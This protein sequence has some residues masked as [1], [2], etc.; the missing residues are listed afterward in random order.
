MYR[1]QF[2]AV[3]CSQCWWSAWRTTSIIS[4][5]RLM[6]HDAFPDNRGYMTV[7][8]ALSTATRVAIWTM[9]IHTVKSSFFHTADL[10]SRWRL[11]QGRCDSHAEETTSRPNR[12]GRRPRDRSGCRSGA[13]GAPFGW[14]REAE[15]LQE[16]SWNP[17]DFYLWQ[18]R[19][20]PGKMFFLVE[21]G[22]SIA[23]SATRL[24]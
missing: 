1:L 22:A 20:P 7:E 18:W 6:N 5:L 11:R 10:A 9:Q 23:P 15:N 14:P 24:D 16:F 21:D 8:V 4:Y 12:L 13:V 19:I 17:L 2:T 3:I